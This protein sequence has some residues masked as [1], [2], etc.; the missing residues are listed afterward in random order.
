MKKI[1]LII[2]V[3]L[4]GLYVSFNYTSTQVEGFGTQNYQCPNI[5]LKRG[6]KIFLKKSG[7]AEIPGVNPIV[8]NNLEEYVEFLQWQRSQNINC[9][10][11]YLEHSYNAQGEE[12]YKMRPNILSPQGGLNPYTPDDRDQGEHHMYVGE[13]T[14]IVGDRPKYEES[15]L[16][17]SNRNDPPYNKHSYPGF[18]PQDQYIG[19]EVP[20][21]KMFHEQENNTVSDNPMDENWGGV[22]YTKEVVKSGKY[23]GDDVSMYAA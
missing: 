12:V 4:L 6:N 5:L 20:L 9:P 2:F 10:V 17:D 8:F 19:L 11:L 14:G 1:I 16:F 3:F 22:R 13:T 21:D 7:K 15:L 18:D 23:S